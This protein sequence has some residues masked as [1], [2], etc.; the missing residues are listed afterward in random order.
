VT[1]RLGLWLIDAD[2]QET[3]D[4]EFK[5]TT[6]GRTEFRPAS[7]SASSLVALTVTGHASTGSRSRVCASTGTLIHAV[8]WA[9]TAGRL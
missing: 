5:I 1:S 6:H 3:F 8:C 7:T 4:L 2:A 9:G